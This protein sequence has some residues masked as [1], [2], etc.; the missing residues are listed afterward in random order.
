[1]KHRKWLWLTLIYLLLCCADGG[2]TYYNTPDLKLEANP[3]VSK[4]GL[5]WGALFT[6][7]AIGLALY[8]LLAWCYD[9]YYER[10]KPP[11]ISAKGFWEYDA[12]LFYGENAKPVWLLYKFPKYWQPCWAMYGFAF[13]YSMILGRCI[14]IYQWLLHTFSIS[15]PAYTA[16]RRACPGSRLDVVVGV[17]S[18]IIL[19]FWWLYLDYR[20][21]QSMEK[22]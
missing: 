5:G 7:N 10:I 2:L 4:L 6:A 1:M 17:I 21:N 15:F 14:I 11:H 3:L 9:T 13:A 22:K 19:C 16:L 18:C 8:A 20:R 12:K